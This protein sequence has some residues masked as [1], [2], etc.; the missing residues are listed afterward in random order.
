[1]RRYTTVSIT[2]CLK[3]LQAADNGLL[4]EDAY[5]QIGVKSQW[6]G[7]QAG[8]CRLTLTNPC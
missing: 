1:L 6:Q 7:N 2:E 3:K 5:I 4:Y 8:R